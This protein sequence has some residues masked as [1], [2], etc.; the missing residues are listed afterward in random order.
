[1]TTLRAT[2]LMS[3]A[4]AI[5]MAVSVRAQAQEQEED[6]G[7]FSLEEA[8]AEPKPVYTSEIEGGFAWQSED[9]FKFG[10]FSGLEDDGIHFVGGFHIQW[11]DMGE[12]SDGEYF[13]GEGSNLGLESRYL[14]GEYGRQGRFEVHAFFDQT[15]KFFL[16][17]A[18]TFFRLRE[19]GT[20][21]ELPAGWVPGNRD[22]SQMTAL[23]PNLE[24]VNIEHDRDK[25]GGGFSWMLDKNWTFKGEFSRELKDGNRTIA[26]GF[27]TNGG[28]P[29]FAIVP[30]PID[31]E[32]D[33]LDLRVEFVGDRG[34]AVLSYNL[35]LF[36]NNKE[37]LHFENPYTGPWA[38]PTS[39]PTGV[40]E[41]ALPPDNEAHYVML[42]GNYILSPSTRANASV[43]YTRMTQDDQFLP[44][45]ANPG[46]VADTPLPRSNLDG[47]INTYLANLRISSRVSSDLR[48]RA[49][50]RYEN[51]D[52]D[53]PRDVFL[54][55]PADSANQGTVADSTARINLPYS[56]KQQKGELEATYRLFD[57]TRLE[58]GYT[59]EQFERSFTE[60]DK[61]REHRL[62]TKL[63]TSPLNVLNAWVGFDYSIRGGTEYIDNKAFIESHTP[64]FLGPNPE[65]EF[66][67]HPLLRKYYI[68]DRNEAKTHGALDWIATDKLTVG[69][70]GD[71]RNDDYD[72]TRIGLTESTQASATIDLSYVPTEKLTAYAFFTYENLEWEQTGLSHQPFPPLNDIFDFEGQAWTVDTED[73]VKTAG[74]GLEWVAIADKLD[75]DLDYTFSKTETDFDFTAGTKLSFLELPKLET[76]RHSVDA[77]ADYNYAD[78]LTL[79]LRYFFEDFKSKDF[80]LDGINPDSMN[81]V[82]GLGNQSPD[83]SAH[84]VGIS[85]VFRF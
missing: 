33:A 74:L 39:F 8:P 45:T 31:Y 54:T 81:F 36:R 58:A 70:R 3:T 14:Y 63:S 56:R 40:G 79:R 30:E 38:P 66:E 20:E 25:T 10:E 65:E 61:S 75:F 71:Y 82:I 57:T 29:A 76:T 9:S 69:L 42:T 5:A 67:N 17:D 18:R 48:L 23:N 27:G 11:R 62:H 24:P 28:N 49:E 47:E 83:Y 26:V 4:A 53:T 84:V 43:S 80:A 6:F 85:T 34:S 68:A 64:E 22:I 73:D 46:L 21:L 16:D 1:M 59:F 78:N 51:R 32:T 41:M 55:I 15:P 12:D 35:S 77:R 44:F 50:Y 37:T 2:I 52:N 72:D 13:I 7:A 19:G 60:R